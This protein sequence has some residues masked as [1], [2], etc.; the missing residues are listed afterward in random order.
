MNCLE[1][2]MRLLAKRF[3]DLAAFV[4]KSYSAN[5]NEY[6]ISLAK[7]G[8]QT[9]RANF[10]GKQIYL[11]SVYDPGKEAERALK[12]KTFDDSDIVFVFGFGL[13]YQVREIVRKAAGK[14]VNIVV[15]EKDARV[16]R[17]ALER[18][19]LSHVLGFPVIKFLIG[20]TETEI[21]L[22]LL[23][24]L[25][26]ATTKQI[27]FFEN[28]PSFQLY[29]EY[30]TEVLRKVRDAVSEKLTGI[31]TILN[32][33]GKW[34]KNT[35]VNLPAVYKSP[36]V[37]A[38]RDKFRGLPAIIVS[39][40]PSLDK[41]I[42]ELRKAKG[43]AVI[44]AVGTSLRALL[45]ENIP[46]D[47]VISLDAGEANYEHFRGIGYG[48]LPLVFD[49]M[50]YPQILEDH[51]GLKFVFNEK[52]TWLSRS[53]A[54]V[55]DKGYLSTGSSIATSAFSLAL[56]I[57]SNPVIFVGQDLAY[58]EG[59]SHAS[60]SVYGQKK[61][62]YDDPLHYFEVPGYY[63]KPV[64]THRTFYSFLKWFETKI[65][66]T[67]DRLFINA[68]EGGAR[69]KGAIQL[70]LSE[71]V[72]KYCLTG[73]DVDRILTE[74]S[75]QFQP[76]DLNKFKE[77]LLEKINNLE[78][79]SGD[80]KQLVKL[81]EELER[82]YRRRVHDRKKVKKIMPR[83]DVL[84]AAIKSNQCYQLLLEMIWDVLLASERGQLVKESGKDD[85]FVLA[86]KRSASF[87]IFYLR[88]KGA[89]D[90]AVIWFREALNAFNKDI[91]IRKGEGKCA[92]L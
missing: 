79:L 89:S 14:K 60:A 3:P 51:Q 66:E 90:E 31:A 22:N 55:D 53:L 47:L 82:M 2:N 30:Y 49:L 46:P 61:V 80:A 52:E 23:T 84:E 40:G 54:E 56:E 36:G 15:I 85:D 43:K 71:A 68:T 7:N 44:I 62:E 91:S 27:I 33:K 63:G 12:D 21:Y 42:K 38:I 5:N 86:E 20:L 13:G 4:Q 28:Q 41:N 74:I 16:F 75:M 26:V 9:V 73:V 92:S 6:E 19:D 77:M 48:K 39:A 8:Q 59:R 87:K 35:L 29:D 18:I 69:I 34:L 24:S 37:S 83:I 50:V 11:H 58:S 78:Q 70:P 10:N 25:G 67:T 17:L 81:C 32:F 88:V 45:R 72:E 57:G 76:G 1:T 65:E 64:T